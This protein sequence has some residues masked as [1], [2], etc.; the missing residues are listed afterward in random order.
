MKV[1]NL[2]VWFMGGVAVPLVVSGAVN[3]LTITEKGGVTTVN[4]PI[5]IGRPFVQAEIANA[6][7]A[8]LD[9][10]PVTT[11]ADV[12]QR[13]PDGSVK[14]AVISFLI[15]QLNSG[16]TVTVT[17][18]NQTGTTNTPL[19][20]AQMLGSNY[21]FNAQMN[22]TSG[23]TTVTADARQML[24]NSSYTLWTSGAVAQTVILADHSTARAYDVGFDANRSFRPIF[25][26][27]FWPGI[28]RVHVRFVGEVANTEALQSLLYDLAL[29]TGNSP[30]AQVYT[31]TA[32]PHTAGSRWT[33][34]F[35]IGGA[36]PA[37][38]INHN[39]PYLTQT[40]FSFN[41]DTSK[42]PS[43]SA[44][45]AA[46]TTWQAAAKDIRDP[47]EWTKNMPQA[48]G[49]P[50]IAPYPLWVLYYLYTGDKCMQDRAFGNAD[51]AAAW[52]YHLREGKA[53]KPFVR[54][55]TTGAALG[56]VLS[57]IARPTT[58]YFDLAYTGTSATDQ[59][60]A[61]GGIGG[62]GWTYDPAHEP[63]PYSILYTV[64]GDFFYL[65]EMWFLASAGAAANYPGIWERG[66]DGSYGVAMQV[67]MRAIA[68][69]IRNRAQA[70]FNT[71]DGMVEKTYFEQLL[72][73]EIASEE[74][75]HNITGSQFQ[76]NVS[77]NW[78]RNTMAP[79]WNMG[80]TFG[81]P[82]FGQWR[83]GDNTFVQPE[84]GIDT[85]VTNE[86]I[87]LF[88]QDY[89]VV[90]MG[91]AKEL[92]YPF[93]RLIS[94]V[95]PLHVAIATNAALNPYLAANGR[96]P[97]TRKSDG[98]Y[99]DTL[100]NLKTGYQ[101]AWQNA[102]N[103]IPTGQ[104]ENLPPGGYAALFVAA[105]SMLANENGGTP[106]WNW[107]STNILKD[108]SF[109]DTPSWALVPRT[110][111]PTP[112]CDLNGDG[113]VDTLDV[114]LAINQSLGVSACTNGDLDKSGRCDVVDVQRVVNAALG[115]A[116][117]IGP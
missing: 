8:I 23:T 55:D 71:P 70:A 106:A 65:E 29:S 80:P 31:K 7:Q 1:L 63:D 90:A 20:Q 86:A 75:L 38:A 68:W 85:T 53:G 74:G 113:R 89:L 103:F 72:R 58:K 48:G 49:R 76:G 5:Q 110:P 46:C 52:S 2:A 50:E 24:T 83:R 22:L 96:M 69:I 25:H 79:A 33:K 64:S 41:Y 36:P 57:L 67:Q 12:K 73:D 108:P 45:S 51:L 115:G 61:V 104:T 116:C 44:I 99:F 16:A 56:R 102:T 117:R 112:T 15:P 95:A 109:N 54:G 93:D 94:W 9:G 97:T 88:E 21:N 39:L 6:P 40:T 43:S 10:T 19:T 100:A 82:P 30:S 101:A 59:I 66:P 98:N 81:L 34:D 77:W 92:G 87:S 60:V 32:I 28:N 35:W 14:H 84:Y 13:W 62:D 105:T 4:Y 47:G 18:R 17:F 107:V 11:Q 91:R 42:Q 26:A 114:Q 37:V 27:T 3:S 78:G 111:P